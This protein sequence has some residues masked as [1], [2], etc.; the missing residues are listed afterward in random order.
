M[1]NR[2][3]PGIEED[4]GPI[5]ERRGQRDLGIAAHIGAF[6]DARRRD[7]DRERFLLGRTT[8]SGRSDQRERRGQRDL[9]LGRRPA[10]DFEDDGRRAFRTARS[11]CR[12]WAFGA[13]ENS[14]TSVADGNGGVR[15]A[16]VD[17]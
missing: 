14:T 8:G 4:A 15:A 11:H 6:G 17:A 3:R 12:A 1:S 5:P 10:R 7:R 16:T 13:A 9:G 2:A